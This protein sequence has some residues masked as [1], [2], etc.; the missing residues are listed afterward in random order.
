MSSLPPIKQKTF[1]R[2]EPQRVFNTLTTS[3]GWDSWF[4]QGTIVDLEGRT[5]KFR[6][7]NWGPD[8]V[9]VEDGGPILTLSPPNQFSFMWHP[10]KS[11]TTV[12]FLLEPQGG[13][14]MVTVTETGYS[15]EPEDI[16]AFV[17]CATGWGEALTLLKF[18]MEC[19]I[20]YGEIEK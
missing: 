14:T 1:I 19:G 12:S 17:S 3:E 20:T 2:S 16:G 5:I 11:Y 15:M 13:G 6:W 8:S 10:G 9:T 7:E 18:Y 4:T